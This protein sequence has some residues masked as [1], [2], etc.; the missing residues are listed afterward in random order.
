MHTELLRKDLK[1]V[2][3]ITR[4]CSLH[5]QRHRLVMSIEQENNHCLL[6]FTH[7]VVPVKWSP[8]NNIF[9]DVSNSNLISHKTHIL[10]G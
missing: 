8:L 10:Y 4:E 9:D 1:Y 3:A 2:E 6:T 5:K 7:E